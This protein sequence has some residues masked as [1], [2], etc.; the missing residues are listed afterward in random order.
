MAE[1]RAPR[2]RRK[3]QGVTMM[4]VARHAGVS[5]STVSLFLRRPES[6]SSSAGET[7]QTAIRQL[8]YV[9]NLIA[10][11]LAAAS[12]R[13]VGVVVPSV[14]NAFF[15]ETVAAL[16][17]E[18]GRARLQMLLGHT[19]YHPATEEELVRATLSWAPAAIVVT[20]LHHSAT[21]ERMLQAAKIPVVQIWELGGSAPIDLAVGF[22]HDQVGAAAARHLVSRGYRS[23]VYL[24]GRTHQDKRAAQRAEGFLATARELGVPVRHLTHPAAATTELGGILFTQALE[25]T[26]GQQRVGIGCS[27]D[28]IALGVVFEAQRRGKKIPDEYAVIGFGDLGFAASCNPALSTIRP[29]GDLIGSEAARLIIEQLNTT[30]PK[31]NIVIDTGFSVMHRQST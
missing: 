11:G 3:I 26:K 2:K 20:G 31:R 25:E 19:E 21:T 23:L 7:I 6:V 30:D 27:N 24:S 10:G 28:S 16:Q 17:H 5:P 8:N 18:L 1:N 29:A 15:A 12:S 22:H 4:D 14:R 9:P 13:V